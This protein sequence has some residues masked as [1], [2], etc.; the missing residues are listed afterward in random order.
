[1]PPS[2][3]IKLFLLLV[4]SSTMSRLALSFSTSSPVQRSFMQLSMSSSHKQLLTSL[5][6]V[7]RTR[8]NKKCSIYNCLYKAHFFSSK[9]QRPANLRLRMSTAEEADDGP[10]AGSVLYPFKDVEIK[11]Q[12]YWDRHHTFKTPIRDPNKPKKYV[13]DMFPYPSGA[14]L[15]VGHPE[16]YTGK[17]LLP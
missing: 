5:L 8:S 1:M 10:S 11:W 4:S 14:G 7:T 15:H 2:I 16:G 3:S 13:L 6:D 17:S 12:G 9:S